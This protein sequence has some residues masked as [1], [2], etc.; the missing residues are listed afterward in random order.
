MGNKKKSRKIEVKPPALFKRGKKQVYYVRLRTKLKDIWVSTKTTDKVEAEKRIEQI[1]QSKFKVAAVQE[2][3]DTKLDRNR[4]IIEAVVKTVSG[5]NNLSTLR[6]DECFGKWRDLYSSYS[7][8]SKNTKKFYETVFKRFTYWCAD[9]GIEFIEHVDRGTALSYSKHLWDSGVGGKTYNDHLKNIS[10]VFATIDATTPLPYRDPFNRIHIKRK[11]K[12]ESGTEGH[13]ALEPD[14]LK[15]V[16]DEAANHGEDYRDL[17]ILC[18]QTGLRL[19][20]AALLKWKN[21]SSDFIV[22]V[23][24]KTLRTGNIAR[25]PITAMLRKVLEARKLVRAKSEYVIP[26][27][28]EHYLRNENFVTKKCKSIFEN[29]LNE[30]GGKDITRKDKDG[31]HRKRRASV[32]STHSLRTTYMSLLATQDVSVR[33]A[34]RIL[35]W[36]SSDMIRVYEKMLEAYK[37]DADKRALKIVSRINEFNL[38]VPEVKVKN[39]KLQPTKE[40]LEKLVNQYSNIT[41]GCIYDISETAVRKWLAKFGI[42]RKVRIESADLSGDGIDMIRKELLTESI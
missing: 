31:A 4:K 11:K 38:P 5:E 42:E 14:M 8:L 23:P 16:I 35:A 32:Y 21:I 39:I 20:C 37:G 40:K 1:V 34:M 28:A 3:E 27:V 10:R 26:S 15:A 29:A 17:I 7:G 33:D 2:A 12:S 13:M 9:N 18:S 24:F 22:V 41:I 6:L 19:K 25:I 30:K 36:E